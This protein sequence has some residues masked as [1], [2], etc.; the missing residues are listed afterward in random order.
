MLITLL[1]Y[2]DS[3]CCVEKAQKTYMICIVCFF[4]PARQLAI[5]C[6]NT[7]NRKS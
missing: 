1:A 2:S 6:V 4:L 3:A 5:L 7:G